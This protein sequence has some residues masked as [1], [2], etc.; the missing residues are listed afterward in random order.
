MLKF[1]ETQMQMSKEKLPQL[2]ACLNNCPVHALTPEI[3]QQVALFA[4]NDGYNNGNNPEYERLKTTFAEY[5]GIEPGTFNWQDFNRTLQHYNAWDVQ[6]VLGPVLRKFMKAPIES[7]EFTAGLAI[8]EGKTEAEYIASLTEIQNNCRYNTLSP[9]QVAMYIGF[10]L[11][12]NIGYHKAGT[13]KEFTN[14]GS[15][16]PNVPAVQIYHSGEVEGGSGH[17]ER[18][19]GAHKSRSFTKEE[20]QLFS[21]TKLLSQAYP[22]VHTA[23]L[24]LLKIDV[25]AACKSQT[26]D[27]YR[28]NTDPIKATAQAISANIRDCPRFGGLINHLLFIEAIY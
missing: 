28:L 10:P 4:S 20:Q 24:E 22:E 9:D 19:D 12:F 14:T 16:I 21:I 2:S 26:I 18:S 13:Y 17:F 23:G 25:Q 3:T 7:H 11:G 6:H 15:F 8:S 5:Y 27:D 1:G